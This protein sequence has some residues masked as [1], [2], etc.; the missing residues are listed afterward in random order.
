MD[1]GESWLSDVSKAGGGQLTQT[2]RL[3]ITGRTE[4]GR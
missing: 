1:E 3:Y 2:L 4:I